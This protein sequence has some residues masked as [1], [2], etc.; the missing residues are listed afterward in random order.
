MKA[1]AQKHRFQDTLDEMRATLADVEAEIR[2]LSAEDE[3]L[4]RGIEALEHLI[5][6]DV[7]NNASRQTPTVKSKQSNPFN[8]IQ[9]AHNTFEK[10]LE[11]ADPESVASKIRPKCQSEMRIEEGGRYRCKNS[12]CRASVI[13]DDEPRICNKCGKKKHRGLCRRADLKQATPP[14]DSISIDKSLKD[15]DKQIEVIRSKNFP[16][17]KNKESVILADAEVEAAK[18]RIEQIKKIVQ[19]KAEQGRQK[20]DELKS[21]RERVKEQQKE[22]SKCHGPMGRSPYA[23]CGQCMGEKTAKALHDNAK[24]APSYAHISARTQQ[25][26]EQQEELA[27]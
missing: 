9:V 13:R 15:A 26:R 11:K 3:A 24:P 6:V 23:V 1:T 20:H 2:S 7:E 25:I 4:R 22:C 19:Q 17:T 8:A 18:P 14:D 21:Y 27:G 16:D 10:F 12:K 5:A